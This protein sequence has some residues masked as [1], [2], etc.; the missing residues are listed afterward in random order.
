MINQTAKM[1]N[2]THARLSQLLSLF[3]LRAIFLL[4]L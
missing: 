1:Q 3:R 4:L 2:L